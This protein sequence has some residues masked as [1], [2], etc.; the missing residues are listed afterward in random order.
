[1]SICFDSIVLNEFLDK[2]TLWSLHH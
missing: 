2:E 1:M